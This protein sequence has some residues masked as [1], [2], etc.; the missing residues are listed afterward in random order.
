MVGSDI[1]R[2]LCGDGEVRGAEQH[3]SILRHVLDRRAVRVVDECSE[4]ARDTE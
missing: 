1:R 4:V 3:P 2:I